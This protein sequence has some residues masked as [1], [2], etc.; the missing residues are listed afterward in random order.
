MDKSVN[1]GKTAAILAYLTI[2]GTVI[3]FTLNY[4][5]KKP[6]AS[7]HIRQ[8]LG[9]HIIF[10]GLGLLVSYF[11]SW[12]ISA[13]FYLFIMVLWGYGFICALQGVMRET[14]LI[15][16]YFQTWFRNIG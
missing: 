9:V 10:Y 1:Q 3:A 11:D 8:A 7:F 13:P 16:K 14:P 12:L 5:E 2:I 15:G 6:L 4:D